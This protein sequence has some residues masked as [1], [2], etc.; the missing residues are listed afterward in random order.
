MAGF[1][2]KIG[3]FV[4]GVPLEVT[5][6]GVAVVGIGCFATFRLYRMAKSPEVILKNADR[7]VW[8]INL[9]KRE[10]N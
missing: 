10:S 5:P 4:K 8:D 1:Y 3:R 7:E 6:L 2:S 9:E